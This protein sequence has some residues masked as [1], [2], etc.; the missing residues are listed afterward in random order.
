MISNVSLHPFLL[1]DV[2]RGASLPPARSPLQAPAWDLFLVLASLR[3]SLYEPAS[4]ASLPWFTLKTAFLVMLASGRRGFEV[5]S[6]SG[7][8][9]DIACEGDG[10]VFLRFLPE[11]LARNQVPGVPTPVVLLALT[12]ILGRADDDRLVCPVRVLRFYL[13]RV[14]PLRTATQ[15]RLFLSYNSDFAML[16]IQ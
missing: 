15:R 6:F 1:R 8:S 11:F 14:R 3:R 12:S 7:S 2:I 9:F 16:V 5:H 13:Q 4:D 10:A